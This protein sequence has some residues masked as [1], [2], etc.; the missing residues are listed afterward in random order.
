MEVQEL[1]AKIVG[2]TNE[3]KELSATNAKL[4]SEVTQ[5]TLL[6]KSIEEGIKRDFKQYWNGIVARGQ[7]QSEEPIRSSSSASSRASTVRSSTSSRS[8]E[9]SVQKRAKM[10]ISRFQELREKA[11]SLFGQDAQEPQTQ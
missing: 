11:N 1:Y 5:I 10:A 8:S 3:V 4:K 6:N 2:L 7:Q 9:M